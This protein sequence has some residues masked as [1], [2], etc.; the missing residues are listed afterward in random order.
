MGYALLWFEDGKAKALG[1][2][3]GSAVGIPWKSTCAN[4]DVQGV[5]QVFEDA[6]SYSS[7]CYWSDTNSIWPVSSRSHWT[8]ARQTS[9]HFS[10]W[11]WITAAPHWRW[12]CM[13]NV[14]VSFPIPNA[15][16]FDCLY[17][18]IMKLIIIARLQHPLKPLAIWRVTIRKVI[19]CMSTCLPT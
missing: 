11:L 10:S 3:S 8:R 13:K 18:L 5:E 16:Y 14:T 9:G 4:P 6:F 17:H 1:R 12:S 7:D 15:D 2:E 19:A